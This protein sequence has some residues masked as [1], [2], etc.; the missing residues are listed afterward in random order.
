MYMMYI[1]LEHVAAVCTC[2]GSSTQYIW[3]NNANRL[4][5]NH[6]CEFEAFLHRL[7]VHLVGKVGEAHIAG[8]IRVHEL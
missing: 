2:T 1:I 8:D 6:E 4:T 3:A 7:P 5:Y